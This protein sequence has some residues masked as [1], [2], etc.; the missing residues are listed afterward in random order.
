MRLEVQN[1]M[2]IEPRKIL[3]FK[4]FFEQRGFN[5]REEERRGI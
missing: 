4:D 3:T 1:V 5:L 2:G